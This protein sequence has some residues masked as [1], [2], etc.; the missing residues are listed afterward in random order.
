MGGNIRIEDFPGIGFDS[1]AMIVTALGTVELIVGVLLVLG[2]L[3]RYAAALIVVYMTITFVTLGLP[4]W[5]FSVLKDAAILGS[6]VSLALMGG[7]AASLDSKLLS[8][9]R[10]VRAGP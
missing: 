6:A 3:T 2:L 4:V 9:W 1:A 7:G 8:R 10:P 5:K